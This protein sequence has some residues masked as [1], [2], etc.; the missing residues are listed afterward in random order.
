MPRSA[1]LGIYGGVGTWFEA[2]I[3]G[4]HLAFKDVGIQFGAAVEKDRFA[5]KTYEHNDQKKEGSLLSTSPIFP[6]ALLVEL[7]HEF[8]EIKGPGRA[9]HF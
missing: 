1:F 4:F 8:L 7:G 6:L 2:G 5:R 3:G 9:F